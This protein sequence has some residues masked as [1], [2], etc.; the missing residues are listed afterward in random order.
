MGVLKE[1]GR[2]HVV[3]FEIVVYLGV[4]GREAAEI[5]ASISMMSVSRS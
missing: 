2:A 1:G 5:A 3:A 4:F